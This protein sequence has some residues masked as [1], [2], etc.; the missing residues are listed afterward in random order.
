[1]FA[2]AS[3]LVLPCFLLASEVAVGACADLS[4]PQSAD[5]SQIHID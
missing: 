5:E 2:L 4:S 1:M 3:Q